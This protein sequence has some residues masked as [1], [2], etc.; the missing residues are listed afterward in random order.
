[1]F[2]AKK[3]RNCE[4][5]KMTDEERR[6]YQQLQLAFQHKEAVD[7]ICEFGFKVALVGVTAIVAIVLIARLV[8]L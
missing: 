6:N 5:H 4:S 1:V 2:A 8:S 3:V 7:A